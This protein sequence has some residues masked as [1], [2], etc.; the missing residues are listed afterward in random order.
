[1]NWI[2]RHHFDN[3]VYCYPTAVGGGAAVGGGGASA[4]AGLNNAR[5]R[6]DLGT[7]TNMTNL[8]RAKLGVMADDDPSASGEGRPSFFPFN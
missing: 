1:M 8:E 5:I 6:N 2:D 4:S 3:P 7:K